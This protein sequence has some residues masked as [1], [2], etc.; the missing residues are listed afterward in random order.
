M[1]DFPEHWQLKSIEEAMDALIDYRGKTPKKT[2]SGIPLITAKIVK[3]GRIHEPSEFIAEDNYDSWMVR[4]LPEV[5]DVVVTTEAPLGEVAQINNSNIALAQRI[6]T[7][8]GKKGL[9]NNDFLLYAMQSG[10]IQHQL[11]SRASGST[12]K[13]IKQSELRK[14]LVPIPPENEQI[15]IAKHLKSI[16]SKIALNRQINQT[17]ESISQAI[18]KS[19]FVD[20]EPVK[21]KIAALESSNDAEGVTCAAMRA[22]SGK[23]DDELDKMEGG[24]PENYAQLKTTAELFPAAMQDSEL[25]EVPEGW[26][27]SIIGEEVDVVGGGT[28][29]TKNPEFW[30]GGETHWTTPKDLSNLSDKV[31]L[32]TNRKITDAGLKKISSGLLP[33]NTVLM[34]SRAP[35][36]YLALAKVPV[37]VNQGYI[38]MLCDKQLSPEFV[39][40]W[41]NYA[42]YEI[43][44]R[45]SGTTFAEI[46]K[47]NF[48]V[49]PLVIPSEGIQQSYS[50]MTSGFY[51][52]ITETAMEC[53]N[54]ADIRDSLLPKLL[55]GEVTP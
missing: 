53:K 3:N 54:L 5:G 33:V 14:V 46:S 36:G 43:K 47:K 20:F 39:I 1:S 22:I 44:Q 55:S 25:G 38:A 17:L 7:L 24:Q 26:E 13:G 6:V 49:I 30:E 32:T 15:E 42:M 37:A 10:F 31:L 27:V 51:D 9:L 28:P 45:S 2:A 52:K 19:W 34:S 40:Q 11:E 23:T 8:R 21:A 50:E 12:V 29:S 48:K 18:F 41:C 16:D 35:V 4:G